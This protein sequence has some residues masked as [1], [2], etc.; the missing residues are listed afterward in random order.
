MD[1]ETAEKIIDTILG[2][3]DKLKLVK[4]IDGTRTEYWFEFKVEKNE[5]GG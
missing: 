4:R 3:M 2:M 5:D 1:I